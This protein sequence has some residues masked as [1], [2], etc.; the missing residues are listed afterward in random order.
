MKQL[1]LVNILCPIHACCSSAL[2]R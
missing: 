2:S 1:V